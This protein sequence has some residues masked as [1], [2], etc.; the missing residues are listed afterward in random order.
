M[1][2]EAFFVSIYFTDNNVPI[3][4]DASAT[5]L[6]V[7][8]AVASVNRSAPAT[9]AIPVLRYSKYGTGADECVLIANG[10]GWSGIIKS[11]T[12]SI[13]F[14]ASIS[15]ASTW[16]SISSIAFTLFSISPR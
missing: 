6:P 5:T 16:R 4:E 9:L 13:S 14:M 15:G 2:T 1:N 3:S 8:A 11:D 12:S 10:V 7:A